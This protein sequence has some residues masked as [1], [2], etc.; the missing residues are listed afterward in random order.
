MTEQMIIQL[1]TSFA[2]SLA[3]AMIFGLRRRYL[4]AAGLGGLISWAV[5][6]AV[7]SFIDEI[8]IGCLAA[9][10]VAALFADILAHVYKAPATLFLIP[11]LIP[12]IPGSSLYY[13]MSSLVRQDAAGARYYGIDTIKW[14]LA[15][16]AGISLV[17]AVRE[18][19][20]KKDA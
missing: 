2:G 18:L 9:A 1:A 10:S 19:R 8:F 6:L 20:T 3:F 12:L 4:L 16:A 15:I 7:H 14:A 17:I 5:Y 11:S 13:T